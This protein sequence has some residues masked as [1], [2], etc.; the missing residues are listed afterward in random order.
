MQ[1]VMPRMSQ[2]LAIA[3]FASTLSL[4]ALALS[5]SG[6]GGVESGVDGVLP[7]IAQMP[8]AQLPALPAIFPR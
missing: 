1:L 4:T 5:S 3:A 8:T 7:A 2:Q 6:L